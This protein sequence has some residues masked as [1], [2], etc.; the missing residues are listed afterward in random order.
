MSSAAAAAPRR[1]PSPNSKRARPRRRPYAALR[2]QQC[3]AATQRLGPQPDP[4]LPAR[5]T[6]GAQ[7]SVAQTHLRK[8]IYTQLI[9]SMPTLR[10]LFVT[11]ASRLARVGGRH[12]LRLSRKPATDALY[13]SI[14][15]SSGRLISLFSDW[16]LCVSLAGGSPAAPSQG[17][18]VDKRRGDTRRPR[19]ARHEEGTVSI[20]NWNP[21]GLCRTSGP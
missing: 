14:K 6:R 19:V 11:R 18:C 10:L 17:G 1:R 8:R 16:G 13:G 21:K 15:P 4:E 9:R 2:R 3:L 7:T 20:A 12:V 5:H